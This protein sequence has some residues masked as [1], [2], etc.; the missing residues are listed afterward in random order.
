MAFTL[1]S[2]MLINIPIFILYA[3][4]VAVLGGCHG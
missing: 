2:V 4:F 1:K 3:A